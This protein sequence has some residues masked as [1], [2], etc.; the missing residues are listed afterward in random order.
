MFMEIANEGGSMIEN[1]A[2]Q[3]GRSQFSLPSKEGRAASV[4]T[5]ASLND[6]STKG[7]LSD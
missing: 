5:A 3:H 7:D 2:G 4:A 6:F 1:A